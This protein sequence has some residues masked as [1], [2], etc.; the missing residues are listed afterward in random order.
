M[1]RG[2]FNAE[3]EPHPGPPPVKF[4]PFEDYLLWRDVGLR[5]RFPDGRP[6]PSWRG[7]PGERNAPFA[8]LLI[9]TRVRV[10]GG[11]CPLAPAPPGAGAAARG[12]GPPPISPPPTP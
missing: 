10:C 4:V 2:W 6:D 5:G 1:R 9:F 12:P 7:R 3:S 11:S 8:G